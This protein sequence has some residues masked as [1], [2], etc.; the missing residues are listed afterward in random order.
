MNIVVEYVIQLQMKNK[1][2]SRLN[3]VQ[4]YKKM[5]LPCELVEFLGRQKIKK[6]REE[7]EESSLKWKCRFDKVLI[8]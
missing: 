2:I 4:I 6:V 3:Q 1:G 5:I 7:I 8:I